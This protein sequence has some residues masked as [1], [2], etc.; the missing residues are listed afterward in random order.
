[1]RKIISTVNAPKAIGPYSQAVEIDNTIYV[2]GQ[3]AMK[4][5][6]GVIVDGGIVEQTRQTLKNLRGV[7]NEGGYTFGNVVKCTCY[8]SDFNDYKGFN[9]AYGEYFDIE[10]PARS[11]FEVGALPIGAKIKIECIAV[12]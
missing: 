9:E 6:N 10:P 5:E 11:T 3:I 12:K 2:S 4:P 8:L 1:M 7:L